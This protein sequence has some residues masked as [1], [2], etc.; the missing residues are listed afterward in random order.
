MDFPLQL[1][2]GPTRKIGEHRVR[3][4]EKVGIQHFPGIHQLLDEY[5][6]TSLI[7]EQDWSHLCF[8]HI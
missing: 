2:S 8:N 3:S 6:E 4:L 7:F 1:E 5:P